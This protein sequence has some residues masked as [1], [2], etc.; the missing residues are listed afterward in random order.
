[1]TIDIRSLAY[2]VAETTDVAA[3]KNYAENVIGA[4]TA[5]TA[6]GGLHVKIDE[7]QQ[8]MVI[9]KGD[10]NRLAASG[11]EVLGPKQ[12][13]AAKAHLESK[14]VAFTAGSKEDCTLR[15]VQE[16]VTIKDPAGNTLE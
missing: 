3:W 4:M 6:E 13:A 9:R 1:M 14:G 11:W 2:L 5:P 8:R 10:N 7:R 12:F 15:C 16:M